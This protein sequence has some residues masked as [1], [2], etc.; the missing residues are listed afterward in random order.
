MRFRT[1]CLKSLQRIFEL[2]S[3][4]S[5][6]KRGLL[7]HRLRHHQQ[8]QVGR[9]RLGRSRRCLS[10]WRFWGKASHAFSDEFLRDPLRSRWTWRVLEG[11]RL[12]LLGIASNAPPK[13]DGQ[14][15]E[16]WPYDTMTQ[17]IRDTDAVI[18]GFGRFGYVADRPL[19]TAVYRLSA[20]RPEGREIILQLLNS[21]N[22]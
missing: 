17:Q 3:N 18:A 22:S 9:R 5:T 13:V 2:G 1:R 20:P 15:P 10:S 11:S 16:V 14:R 19:A 12:R 4:R 21:G 7:R 8:R 6:L